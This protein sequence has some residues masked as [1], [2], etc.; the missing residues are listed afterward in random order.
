MIMELFECIFFGSL[1]LLVFIGITLVIFVYKKGNIERT[2]ESG[3]FNIIETEDWDEENPEKK[4]KS[5]SAEVLLGK[6]LWI[7]PI[8]KIVDISY[9]SDKYAKHWELY[10]LSS[11]KELEEILK[12][13]YEETMREKE[14]CQTR[15]ELHK[16][17]KVSKMNLNGE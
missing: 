3:I 12:T 6:Y 4:I 10:E 2:L 5:Y 16:P 17:K 9:I 13:K 8:W 7:I 1:F 11:R 14:I 15:G